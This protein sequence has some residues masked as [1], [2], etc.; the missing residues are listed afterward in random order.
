MQK[1][2]LDYLSLLPYLFLLSR[3]V[4]LLSL[5]IDGLRGYGDFVHFYRLAGM[6]LPFIDIWVEF[7]PIFPAVSALLYQLTGLREHAYD[8]LLVILL[9]L[10]DAANI[11]IFV[12]LTKRLYPA[13]SGWLRA[14]IYMAILTGLAYGWWFFDPL[15]VLFLLLSVLWLVEGH[16][17]RT[18][19]ALSLGALTKWFPLLLL[20]VVWKVRPARQALKIT[21]I[22]LLMVVLVY[23]GLY[24]LAPEMTRAS[25]FAQGSKGSWET[26]WAL[27]DGN[28]QTGNFGPEIERY[29][30]QSAYLARGGPARI[31]PWLTL[32]P[33]A[34]LGGWLWWKARLNGD[35]PAIAFLGL[36]WCL[37]LLWSPGWSPQWVLYLL[38]VVLLVL[39]EREA[40][41][42]ALALVFIN[43]L[44]WPLLLSRGYNWGLWLT[45]PLRTLLLILLA[46]EF[47]QV[48]RNL[49]ADEAVNGV[50]EQEIV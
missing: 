6:G 33:F 46:I 50:A 16:A 48:V 43:L 40:V 49:A 18:G 21:A 19:F 41:L 47:W 34:V 20:P 37:F 35:R 9:T 32:I 36:T 15:A 13:G 17:V 8:Y 23:A 3:A 12:R 29:D 1:K 30:P 4:L 14:A 5:P 24:L 26:V 2:T 45:I 39:A 10:C 42:M 38:P 22:A 28:F 25:L 7:P 44:E 31:P 27:L 11:A